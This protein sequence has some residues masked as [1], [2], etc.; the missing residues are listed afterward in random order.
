MNA[1]GGTARFERGRRLRCVLRT[2]IIDGVIFSIMVGL[3]ESYFPALVAKLGHRQ[4]YVGLIA[5]VP[6]VAGALLQLTTPPLVRRAASNRRWVT[7][8][9]GTQAFSLMLL[10]AGVYAGHPP[11]WFVFAAATL[12]WAAGLASGPAWTDWM[13]RE[14]P[15]PVRGHY[16]AHRSRWCQAGVLIGLLTGGFTLERFAG[17]VLG[18][19]PGSGTEGFHAFAALFFAA[20]LCRAIS[21]AILLTQPEQAPGPRPAPARPAR[22][23]RLQ[24]LRHGP[25]ARLLLYLFGLQ[26]TANLA[27]PFFNPYML[28][29]ARVDYASYTI[30]L[31]AAFAAKMAVF[32]LLGRIV[33]RA[34]AARLLTA[35]GIALIPLPLLWL[36]ARDFRGLLAVQIISGCIWGAYELSSFLMFYR[37][38]REDE[39]TGV[40]A[41]YTF[42]NAVSI[43][44]GSVL[45]GWL[46]GAFTPPGERVGPSAYSAVFL[47][48]TLARA[49][50]LG[51]LYRFTRDP[52]GLT[53]PREPWPAIV[54]EPVAVRPAAGSVD[55]PDMDRAPAPRRTRRTPEI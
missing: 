7:W 5:T 26:A 8:C 33:A 46:L 47:I 28:E 38:I 30:L 51:L 49:A 55:Q 3:G 45:G 23:H 14:I 29:Q 43:A 16:H 50:T 31:S 10:S 18:A 9:T 1:D 12:Y 2:S 21:T 25:E 40:L 52:D 39:R 4:V 20:A 19:G 32:P 13:G 15:P 44:G 48:S 35:A 22:A 17:G 54:L 24:R 42:G 36:A 41:V 11:L 53:E 27:Q 37:A 34:G 6:M